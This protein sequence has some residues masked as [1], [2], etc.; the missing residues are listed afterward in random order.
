MKNT[1][2]I[3]G[4]LINLSCFT[5]LSQ[6]PPCFPEDQGLNFEIPL[7]HNC[8]P[9]STDMP[10]DVLI[11]YIALDS[12]TKNVD[13]DDY[14]SFMN[15]QT[16]NDTI[17]TMMRYFYKMLEFNPEKYLNYKHSGQINKYEA[18]D[19]EHLFYDFVRR[20]SPEPILDASLLASFVIAKITVNSVYNYNDSIARSAKTASIITA[21]IDSLIKG[22]VISEC[23][24]PPIIG[25]PIQKCIKFEIAK[26]WFTYNPDFEMIPGQSYFVFF[27][28]RLICKTETSSYFTIFPLRFVDSKTN[29]IYPV[30]DN[31]IIDIHNE[32]GF[33]TNIDINTFYNLIQTRVN[34]IKNFTP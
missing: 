32:L 31:S 6:S 4:L 10:F 34:Q 16:Y 30:I 25:S 7:N 3:I 5:L 14:Y 33:G 24:N 2:I 22:K 29:S 15:N 23:P 9:Y 26:E 19:Y 8:P 18:M 17:K 1:I 21:Y 11:G 27:D 28:Y 12:L 13:I 20:I